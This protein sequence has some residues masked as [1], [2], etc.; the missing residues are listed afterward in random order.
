MVWGKG[1]RGKGRGG[2]GIRGKL[3]ARR[4]LLWCVASCCVVLSC[5]G[6]ARIPPNPA[7]R[8]LCSRRRRR[9]GAAIFS[10][11]GRSCPRRRNPLQGCADLAILAILDPSFI[12]T[13]IG[14][15]SLGA[16]T[17]PATPGAAGNIA[18]G[19]IA[20]SAA[21]IVLAAATNLASPL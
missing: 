12:S 5:W 15:A 10:E 6:N 3:E 17:T 4:A 21:G 2:E 9:T 13:T 18:A 14:A 20:G 11:M 1:E 7:I 8:A 19:N 16:T